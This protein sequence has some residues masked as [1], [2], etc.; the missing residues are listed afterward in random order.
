MEKK[1][2][3]NDDTKKKLSDRILA[4]YLDILSFKHVDGSF[5][6]KKS[7]NYG[8]VWLTAF[9]LKNLIHAN[10]KSLIYLEKSAIEKT[11][12]FIGKNNIA[13]NAIAALLF[14]A[15][16]YSNDYKTELENVAKK[17]KSNQNTDRNIA[18]Q[19]YVSQLELTPHLNNL[20]SLTFNDQ[21]TQLKTQEQIETASYA[22]MVLVEA[23][24]IDD[25][26]EIAKWLIKHQ[27]YNGGFYTIR[28]TVIGLQALAKLSLAIA[29]K[30][31]TFKITIEGMT[32]HINSNNEIQ[33][34]KFNMQQNIVQ[35]SLEENGFGVIHIR[36]KKSFEANVLTENKKVTFGTQQRQPASNVKIY[37][38]T[39][40]PT[41]NE[42][43]RDEIIKKY[44]ADIIV[45]EVVLP[46]GYFFD[47]D[48]L[49]SYKEFSYIEV[50][51]NRLNIRK[52]KVL[53]SES[54]SD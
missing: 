38:F 51:L 24:R 13:D 32:L 33:K 28:D 54:R 2:T 42:T 4:G 8:N 6:V 43:N 31:K 35:V 11:I 50:K 30:Y 48:T 46:S 9:V 44:G 27:N 34:G 1:K 25:A 12:K 10:Q 18:L 5:K 15:S 14:E 36:T 3:L 26:I 29:D 47:T 39:V 20:Q 19:S 17:F 16:S 52:I 53:L 21:S 23:G 41:Y 40:C 7:D 49:A 22:I 37:D 45:L